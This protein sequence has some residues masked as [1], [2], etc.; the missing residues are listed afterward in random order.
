MSSADETGEWHG[1][2]QQL[3]INI[4]RARHSAALSQENVAYQ[5]GVSR[6]TYQRIERGIGSDQQPANPTL[7]SLLAIA[8][9]LGTSIEA[10]LPD[11]SSAAELDGDVDRSA[12]RTARRP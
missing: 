5:A 12:S 11:A 10:L 6:V 8:G 9:A 2:M 4:A 7:R 3:G 1:Y